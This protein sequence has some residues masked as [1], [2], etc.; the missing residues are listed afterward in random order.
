MSARAPQCGDNHEKLSDHK[1]FITKIYI[2]VIFR[3]FMKI[4][5][6]ENLELYGIRLIHLRQQQRCESHLVTPPGDHLIG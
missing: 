6:H 4:L 3:N 2:H 5:N 1:L